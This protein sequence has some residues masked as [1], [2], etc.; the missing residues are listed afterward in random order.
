MEK[1]LKS[2]SIDDLRINLNLYNEEIRKTN[3]SYRLKM[4][5]SR[6]KVY[7][8]ELSKRMDEKGIISKRIFSY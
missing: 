1:I 8:K 7:Q 3:Q 4:L 6:K 5:E 2:M